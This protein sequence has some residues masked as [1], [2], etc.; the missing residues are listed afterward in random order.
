LALFLGLCLIL[1]FAAGRG[2]ADVDAFARAKLA[3]EKFLPL[4]VA[5]VG[6]GKFGKVDPHQPGQFAAFGEAEIL[7]QVVAP[8]A[9]G[10]D[11]VGDQQFARRFAGAVIEQQLL[12][13]F[14][15][16][17]GFGSRVASAQCRSRGK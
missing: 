14:P 2:G 4:H 11:D 9:G 12:Q 17:N 16:G 6:A 7:P 5:G 8:G 10:G 1:T 13:V 15:F 3:V